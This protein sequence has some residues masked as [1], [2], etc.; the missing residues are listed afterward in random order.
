MR[1]ILTIDG[2]GVRGVIPATVLAALERTTGR[3]TREHFDFVAGTSTGALLAAGIAAGIPAARMVDRYAERADEVFRRIPILTGL[4]RVLTGVAYDVD[5]LHRLVREELG[6]EAAAWRL[7]DAPIDLLVTAKRLSDGMPWYFVRDDPANSCRAGEYRLVDVAVASASAPT[8]FRPAELP[9]IGE[10]VDG[11]IGVAGNPVYQACVEAFTYS[12]GYEPLDTVV[13]SLGTGRWA[14][15][16]RPG[17]LGDWLGWTL[18]ELLR[19]PAEQQTEL[20]HR[21][22]PSTPFYRIDVELPRDIGLDAV[23]EIGELQRIGEGLAE[24]VPWAS[25]LVASDA[26][27]RVTD[28]RN[29]PREYCRLGPG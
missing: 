10:V 22:W 1:R 20:V 6:P 3:P 2:G 5:I 29:L 16:R 12:T 24:M 27:F 13:V 9:G 18:S 15:R 28:A 8:Y 26:T 19:S 23:A 17:W 14:R 11:G 21:H 25:V 7:N 4:R